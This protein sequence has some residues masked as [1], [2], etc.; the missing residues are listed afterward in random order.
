[1][2]ASKVIARTRRLEIQFGIRVDKIYGFISV[3]EFATFGYVV[4]VSF[5]RKL[6]LNFRE[7]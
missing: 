2:T 7:F 4:G 3:K 5:P 6:K 1:M